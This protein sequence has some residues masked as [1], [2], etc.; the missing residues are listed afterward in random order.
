MKNRGYDEKLKERGTLTPIEV[1]TLRS[2][3][4]KRLREVGIL[5][6]I[7]ELVMKLLS[8][9]MKHGIHQTLDQF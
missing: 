2:D 5:E 8:S 9:K 6:E 4:R 3:L 1:A 7:D